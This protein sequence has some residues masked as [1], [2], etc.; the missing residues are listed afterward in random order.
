MPLL[1]GRVGEGRLRQLL[2]GAAAAA[3]TYTEVGAT[4]GGAGPPG[5]HALRRGT[6]LGGSDTFAPATTCLRGWAAHHGAGVRTVPPTPLLD[7]GGT[8]LVVVSPLPLVTVV[9]PCRIVAVVDEPDRF[10]FAYGT[11]PGHPEVGEEAF[12]VTRDGDATRFDVIAFSRPADR[13]GQVTAPLGRFLQRR[14]TDRYVAGLA[15]CV[16]AGSAW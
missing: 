3:P 9:A 8:V 7:V 10:G 14:Y 6:S 16:A 1:P 11:L 4:L 12:V 13:L 2:D 15:A 5:Y